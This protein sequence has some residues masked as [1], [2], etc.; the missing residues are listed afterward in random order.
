MTSYKSQVIMSRT[1]EFAAL[2]VVAIAVISI[3]LIFV[4]KE[5]S[6]K[7]WVSPQQCAELVAIS[8]IYNQEWARQEDADR[9]KK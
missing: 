8:P 7:V 4:S 9:R 2:L 6:N 5:I 3:C 1:I